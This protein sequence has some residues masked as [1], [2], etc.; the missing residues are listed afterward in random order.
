V[1][2]THKIKTII[3]EELKKR[4]RTDIE[5]DVA[6][7]PEFLKEGSAVDDFLSPDRIVIGT[8]N[9]RTSEFLKELFAPFVQREPRILD[10]SIT[11][12]ELTKYA[13]NAMLATRISFMNELANFCE[14]VGADI[15]E[16]RRGIGTDKRIGP[17]FLYA[18]VGYGGSCFPKDVKALIQSAK[19]KGKS[20]SI[21][22][23]VEDVNK[24]QKHNFLEKIYKNYNN[25]IAGKTF[26]IWGLS[27]KPHTDDI[28]EAPAIDIIKELTTK[29]AKVRAFDPVAID[30]TRRLFENNENVHFAEDEYDA[31]E[32]ADALILV[33][34]WPQFRR[35]DWERMKELLAKPVVF[36]GRNLYDP[37]FSQKE[38]F[39]CYGIG[40]KGQI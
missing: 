25:D 36:D 15:E 9:D 28:R 10:M 34:E 4:G 16:V 14:T 39:V 33:T 40:R 8:E 38:G 21:L 7:C 30:N 24:N 13:A 3:T 22:Q 1:G 18:G 27:F 26:A 6:F 5:F 29:G 32:G 31:L 23:A 20:L 12:A 19:N 11:S 2:T 17:A 37:K 35:P